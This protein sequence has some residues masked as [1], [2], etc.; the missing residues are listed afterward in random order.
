LYFTDFLKEFETLLEHHNK[1]NEDSSKKIKSFVYDNLS[2]SGMVRT[3][4][5][6]NSQQVKRPLEIF[7]TTLIFTLVKSDFGYAILTLE[8]A[9]VSIGLI[10][11]V[12]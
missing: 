5:V 4:E 9:T 10:S 8:L 11:K 6:E 2:R 1:T 12:D 3:K 7:I